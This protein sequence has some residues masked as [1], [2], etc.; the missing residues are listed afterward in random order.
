[1]ANETWAYSNWRSSDDDATRLAQLRLHID[2][3]SQH[4]LGISSRGQS[5]TAV[6]SGYLARL[7]AAEEQLRST[8]SRPSLARNQLRIR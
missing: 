2:E 4:I 1:M 8:V 7:E 5:V 3:V 6:D